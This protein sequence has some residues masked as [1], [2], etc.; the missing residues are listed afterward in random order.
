MIFNYPSSCLSFLILIYLYFLAES[1]I[2]SSA[3]DLSSAS[4]TAKTS[5]QLQQEHPQ[6]LQLQHPQSEQ[7]QQSLLKKQQNFKRYQGH[8]PHFHHHTAPAYYTDLHL[9]IHTP[10]VKDSLNENYQSVYRTPSKLVK[11]ERQ[12]PATTTAVAV[13]PVPIKAQSPQKLCAEQPESTSTTSSASFFRGGGC[14]LPQEQ[15][16][17]PYGTS[18]PSLA[19]PAKG[20][21]PHQYFANTGEELPLA[22]SADGSVVFACTNFKPCVATSEV[23]QAPAPSLA[24][25]KQSPSTGRSSRN[26]QRF[27]NRRRAV[28]V[29]SE[30][31][32]ISAL[33]D[34]IC[35]EKGL[36]ICTT[37]NDEDSSPHNSHDER[38][39]KS[40][41]SHSRSVSKHSKASPANVMMSP[42]GDPSQTRSGSA[43]SQKKRS[44]DK[45]SSP[46]TA[47]F[48]N[49]LSDNEDD[50]GLILPEGGCTRKP[51]HRLKKKSSLL[52]DS[53]QAKSSSLPPGLKSLSDF[54]LNAE[55]HNNH[56]HHVHHPS[57][58]VS[59]DSFK[60]LQTS[61]ASDNVLN[62][63]FSSLTSS[64]APNPAAAL[65]AAT[66]SPVPAQ[67]Q[68]HTASGAG[69]STAMVVVSPKA[70]RFPRKYRHSRDEKPRRHTDGAV[71]L[72]ATEQINDHQQQP[73][74]QQQYHDDAGDQAAH[75]HQHHHRH[76]RHPHHNHHQQQQHHA[77]QQHPHLHDL[78]GAGHDFHVSTNAANAKR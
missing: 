8:H 58:K 72:L 33:Y 29:R 4:A 46:S 45:H 69:T 67:L 28:R 71:Q 49:D 11:D 22:A 77:S 57:S 14:G 63:N 51:H 48:Y 53:Q 55:N 19:N 50:D 76:D 5:C 18:S 66:T 52:G 54:S 73:Q 12:F 25:P 40:R 34:I 3:N 13:A 31:R 43:T 9:R 68:E 75:R 27:N 65:L 2:D 60:S 35:K 38:S 32:P 30:S 15:Q 41:R 47:I 61:S 1:V 16:R 17:N 42:G 26:P 7:Q 6:Q 74:Q 59:Q 10:E 37:T 78:N 20:N 62:A 23:A 24:S 36:D 70:E 44:K 56:H 64:A 21:S 39:S